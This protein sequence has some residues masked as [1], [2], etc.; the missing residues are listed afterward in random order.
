MNMRKMQRFAEPGLRLCLLLMAAFAAVTWFFNEKLAYA[1]AGVVAALIV[2]AV[3]RNRTR[4]REL[5]AFVE[6]VT[7]NAESATNNT[8]IHFP[9]PMAVFRLGDSG[10]VW[11]NQPF[12]DM[13]GRSGPALLRTARE[14]ED[15]S[16]PLSNPAGTAGEERTPPARQ[17]RKS[18]RTAR[19]TQ[20]QRN[21][22]PV[23]ISMAI[24]LS[25]VRVA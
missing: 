1:E 19:S 25:W 2:Y 16:A 23:R 14:E 20:K 4:Q 22:T 7:Y 24:H 13:C 10:V 9:L 18:S 17:V 11:A 5:Q 12:W 21:V 6:S 3:I 8:L 15:S